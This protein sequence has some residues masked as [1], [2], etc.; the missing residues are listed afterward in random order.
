MRKGP[1]TNIEKK[2]ADLSLAA[3]TS[4]QRNNGINRQGESVAVSSWNQHNQSAN[5][6][7]T[8]AAVSWRKSDTKLKPIQNAM[9]ST[10]KT[11]I[12][13]QLKKILRLSKWSGLLSNL[14]K[15]D[16]HPE[17][18][19]EK[20]PDKRNDQRL[21]E[22]AAEA[23]HRARS[24]FLSAMSHEIRTPMNGV[25]GMTELL[26][27]SDLNAHARHLAVTAHRSAEELLNVINDILDY[28]RIEAK[29]LELCEEDFDLRLL[30]EDT[31]EQIA[32]QAKS[33]NLELLP[34]ISL[35]LP[36]EVHGDPV[37]L[38]QVLLNLLSNSVKF[39]EH[40]EI[41]L[42]ALLLHQ[43][44]D[45][46]TLEFEVA[47]TGP[48]IPQ[49]LQ[50]SLFNA[51]VQAD[52]STTRIHSGTGLGLA[53][54]ARLVQMM[55]GDIKLQSTPG[56]GSRFTFHI[57]LRSA[58]R[59]LRTLPKPGALRGVSVLIV[60]D[61][62]VNRE[63]L[64]N[65]VIAWGM[66]DDDAE[67]A[68]VALSKLRQAA[69]KNQP[70]QVM[71]LD[72]Q[73][74]GK[75]GL[76]LAQAVEGDPGIPTP[77]VILLSSAGFDCA[78][79][80]AEETS[81]RC[82]LDKPVRQEKLLRCLL[83]AIGVGMDEQ[84]ERRSDA[85]QNQ[86]KVLL[87]E[88]NPVNQL[89]S[90]G[91]LEELGYQV[92]LSSDG[93]DAVMKS[94]EHNYDLI[95]MDC[96]MP[97]K[98]G[99]EASREIRL[100]EKEQG[101]RAVPI[102][103]LTADTQK[104]IREHCLSAGMN[105]YLSKPFGKAE[106]KQTLR[107]WLNDKAN[108]VH[109]EK[110][111][112]DANT[113]QAPAT[114]DKNRLQSLHSIDPE[115]MKQAVD[116]Y[117]ERAGDDMAA[118]QDAINGA[119]SQRIQRIAHDLKSASATVGAGGA[120]KQLAKVE[121]LARNKEMEAIPALFEQIKNGYPE[122]LHSLH[123][124]AASG[125]VSPTASATPSSPTMETIL[126]VDDDPAF[127]QLT[128]SALRIAGFSVR[129]VANG[130]EAL[131]QLRDSPPNIILLDALM[132]GMDG[133]E[134]CHRVRNQFGGEQIPI[135]MVTGLND[136]KS[137]HKAFDSGAT[138]FITKP[139]N[140]AV[141]IHQIR[142]Q[143]R[144][145]RD[146]RK[147]KE[148]QERLTMAQHIARLGYW[149]W[150]T[151]N[152][153]FEISNQLAHLYGIDISQGL[154]TLDEYLAL[155]QGE[156][157]DLV[158]YNIEAALDNDPLHAVD[159]R[160]LTRNGTILIVHQEL[161]CIGQGVILGTVQ[162]ITHQRETEQTI[163]KLAYS[164][165]LTGLASRAY[166]Q[167]HLEDTIKIAFRH[168]ESFSLL[169]L[170][171]DS[172]KDINDS[173]GHDVGDQLLQVVARRLKM[174]LRTTDFA[175]R[176]GGDEFCI[177]VDNV[178]VSYAA[179]IASRC[180]EEV[181]QPIKL[182][183]Q[184]INPRI[185]IGIANY[186]SDGEDAQTL[187]KAADSAMYAAKQAGKHRYAFYRR[188]LTVQAE[189]RLK[190]EHELRQAIEEGD[191]ELHYQPQ[192]SLTSG[193][194]TGLEALVR[195]QHPT[196]GLVPP[197][198]FI[199]VAERIGLIRA[200]GEWVLDTACQQARQW[201]DAGLPAM[202]IA[203]NISPIHFQDPAI[204]QRVQHVLAETRWAPDNLELEVTEGVVQ[205]SQD[206]LESF[207][208]IKQLGVRIAID[209]FGT[210][211]SS[212]ASLKHLPIDCL[213]VDQLFIRDMMSDTESATLVGT[214]IGLAQA[215]GHE[216]VA[217]GVETQEEAQVLAGLGCELVQGYYFSRPVTADLIPGLMQK[218]FRKQDTDGNQIDTVTALQVKR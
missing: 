116:Q 205:T 198:E 100:L 14:L 149:R 109:A 58:S 84:T 144:V 162:D 210:G 81:I 128:A 140:Y 41:H 72:W 161:A 138:G 209:D 139:V 89:V 57:Q 191:L 206:N 155:V 95:L 9:Q 56:K 46:L 187:L 49:H 48:G 59:K 163:R 110:P 218:D 3:D 71:L 188:E 23:I 8:A 213:K 53:I 10:L 141:L 20:A 132:D 15:G 158:K 170:D 160:I 113:L 36:R 114:L 111:G 125:I 96:H 42:R 11:R 178:S 172:F 62:P 17:A 216:V 217:E 121:A 4:Q 112:A 152:G 2:T 130:V 51:F 203:V 6:R 64:H 108:A 27:D 98:D 166:F 184:T 47:D 105:D 33:K 44:N 135:L 169:Y 142:F 136:L 122:V 66:R 214:I 208:R 21:T 24:E 192:I 189:K 93:R 117:L 182:A 12:S 85:V 94:Q 207:E 199:N 45:R 102:V 201:V 215:L 174:A 164:D 82:F 68:D 127:R 87:V 115:L 129:E 26:L 167:R 153:T 90:V 50:A 180:L 69:N 40:G 61:H 88:D 30:L 197:G 133:F 97:L 211:F 179:E 74:P 123:K 16:E 181:N 32:K 147:L 38:Q 70:Y 43:Q 37:R 118:L 159:Y 67:N 29:K 137:V 193:K 165:E 106:L 185:S 18:L 120:A 143:L 150:D 91:M 65:Q 202:R 148:S 99:F 54:S 131:V 28:S 171:L 173:L 101:K 176:L 63:I 55:R 134:V 146:A 183:Y 145:T 83:N 119:D 156:D 124:V 175:A 79:D 103:A 204:V 31:L 52:S 75:S 104:G 190:M 78:P 157:R 34:E 194:I 35:D 19:E 73:M 1:Q 200:L 92:A 195:W 76:E 212:L 13:H 177:V 39:T 151:R 60:D 186:P 107:Y 5:R 77:A 126:L 7:D 86:G 154:S 80:I 25:L 168:Q 196:R 22:D